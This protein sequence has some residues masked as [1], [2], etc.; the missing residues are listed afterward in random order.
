[1]IN[2]TDSHIEEIERKF[3]FS[4]DDESKEFIKCL[5][6]KDIQA[7]PGAGKTTS[8]VAKLDIIAQHM[9]FKDNSGILV[10]T[11]T[12]V[13]VDE[14]KKKLGLNAKT[15][16]SYPNHVGTFQSFVNKFLAIPMYIKLFGKKPERIDRDVFYKIFQ[17]RFD[18]C[19]DFHKNWLQKRADEKYVNVLTFIEN[20]D[21]SESE[22]KYKGRNVITT[23]SLMFNEIKTISQI[24]YKIVKNGYL[25]YSHCYELALKYL[26]DYENIKE[27]FQKR[28]KYVF[29]DEVQ[30]TDDRQF[31][32]LDKLFSNSDVIIQRIGDKNQAIFSNMNSSSIGWKVNSDFLEIK[33]TKRLSKVISE[34]VTNFAISP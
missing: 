24:P 16:L 6:T 29:V 30:D 15:L 7:C 21:I 11:H 2:I 27:I 10:L 14:I 18:L 25:T 28:F 19:N 1:M 22:I 3:G 33:N 31:E 26:N 8:L 34:K 12:N 13:A 23:S 32:I 9:P 4:F 20:F 17:E 5:K